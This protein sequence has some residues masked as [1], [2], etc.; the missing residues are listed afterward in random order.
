[1]H[2]RTTRLKGGGDGVFG[3]FKAGLVESAC[4]TAHRAEGGYGEQ[5]AR[6]QGF[7]GGGEPGAVVDPRAVGGRE[8]GGFEMD[9]DGVEG[10]G[11]FAQGI[12]SAVVFQEDA[13]IC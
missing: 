7:V 1:M 4:E 8:R 11:V 2:S 12:G 5:T 3:D 10:S 6:L 9:E 13:I